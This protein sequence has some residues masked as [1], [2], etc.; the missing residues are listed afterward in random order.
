MELKNIAV[1]GAAG[2]AGIEAVRHVLGH[3]GFRLIAVSSD[4]D[5]GKSLSD[6]YPA[7][8]GKTDMKFVEHA[9]IESMA[10]LDAVILAVPH[11]A[12]MHMAP[13][14]LAR[15]VAVFD[16]SADFRLKDSAVYEKWYGTKHTAPHLLSSAIYGLP[17]INRALLHNKYLEGA[18]SAFNASGV[19]A[20]KPPVLIACPG[21]Y[22]TASI[23][24]IAPALV[25]D[26]VTDD[27][28]IINAISGV[29]G[30][31]R[32]ANQTT[33]YCA[34]DENLNAYG[35][36]THRHTPEI[37]QLVAWEAG[38]ELPVV[39]TPHLAPLKRGL[40]S[41]ATLRIRP[42]VSASMLL[43]LYNAAYEAEPF[44]SLLPYGQ[45]PKT[46]SVVGTN[47]AQVGIAY[48]ER[49]SVLVASC[50]ID[51]LGKGSASQAIQ[52][53]NVVFG[54]SET[55]GLTTIPGVV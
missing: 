1:V 36:M 13:R 35:V 15:G 55:C 30:A 29:S 12:A 31:G 37:A 17:E 41:T 22:P 5:S 10:G 24:A 40:V 3:P 4:S 8:I 51:N 18:Q 43:N 23:L 45:M 34:A 2:F 44:V 54:L 21:C 42:G 39:F 6:L 16:L 38:R 52:C 32:S 46:S 25:A 27:P 14:L 20:P 49:S 50:A 26:Y 19:G 48:D 11:T 9:T 28:V 33:H 53:A 7:L 47:C